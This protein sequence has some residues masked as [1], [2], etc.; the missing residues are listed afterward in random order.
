MAKSTVPILAF[1]RG[2]ISPLAL[3]R[4]DLD[5][6]RLSA[7]L[8]TNW[9]PKTQGAM[10][11]RPGTKFRGSSL[12]DT[13]A[14]FIE[15]VARTDDAA[16]LEITEGKMRIWDVDTGTISLLGRPTIGIL[17]LSATYTG[18]LNASTGGTLGGGRDDLCS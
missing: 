11:I 7:S 17:S 1:N 9:L 10:I 13:G 14:Y 15:F 2:L 4:V 18:W 5:R 16:L 8:M 6:T 12:N 3:A